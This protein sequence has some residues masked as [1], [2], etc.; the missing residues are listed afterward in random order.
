VDVAGSDMSNSAGSIQVQNDGVF[1]ANAPLASNLHHFIPKI[2][3][4]RS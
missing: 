3:S 4:E 2:Q 1:A